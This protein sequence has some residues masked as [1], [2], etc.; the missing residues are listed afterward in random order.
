MS[1]PTTLQ[2]QA[3][4]HITHVIMSKVG[5]SSD[6]HPKLTTK[7]YADVLQSIME[8]GVPPYYKQNI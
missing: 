4:L 3:A 7:I 2:I 8:Y 1:I 6:Q 5:F